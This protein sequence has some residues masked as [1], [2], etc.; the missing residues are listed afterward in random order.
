VLATNVGEKCDR[1]EGVPVRTIREIL[2]GEGSSEIS[3]KRR[4]QL[5]LFAVVKFSRWMDDEPSLGKHVQ[6]LVNE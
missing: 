2:D 4:D 3:R 6:L 5:Q 1:R